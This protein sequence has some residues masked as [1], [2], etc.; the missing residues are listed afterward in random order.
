MIN[1]IRSVR[2]A[3]IGL[4]YVG[5]PLQVAFS[6]KGFRVVGY[7]ID[8][9]RVDELQN[10]DDRTGEVEKKR[11]N[12]LSFTNSID[13]IRA[14]NTYIIT[15]PTPVDS[16]FQPD[17]TPLREASKLISQVC[18]PGDVVIYESTVYPGAT[19]EVCDPIIENESGFILNK[20]F[21]VGY[22]PE[23]INP[24]DRIN[25]LE[26]IVKVTSGSNLESSLYVDWLYS[27]IIDAGT[28]RA[29]SIRVAEASK[30][31]ENCQRDLNIAFVNE[32]SQIFKRLNIDTNEVLDAAATKWNFLNFRP[33]LVGGHCIGVDPYYLKYKAES[34]GYRPDVIM[35]GRHINN[36]MA[37]A[38]VDNLIEL[39]IKRRV[40]FLG[41]KVLILGFTF[42]ENCP[43]IRNTKVIDVVNHLKSLDIDVTI[44]DKLADPNLS[45]RVY[46]VAT[47]GN[48][49]ENGY[50]VV[51]LAVPHQYLLDSGLAYINSLRKDVS[52]FYDL[53]A[54]YPRELSD[55]RL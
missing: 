4:G 6:S 29:S 52:I 55:I 18:G 28:H 37:K 3:V 5:L 33:G 34:T 16:T 22:S 23:R 49:A 51:I 9:N 17:M 39:M 1:D 12:E 41:A 21:Y 7:D 53:K 10:G 26:T 38:V 15:V 31:I 30:V 36:D 25:T 19:E 40:N 45:K 50:D 13:E 2:L 46:G 24:G 35:A 14:C 20:D 54:A 32:L 48:P 43:D 11:L 27:N 44:S 8:G 42:K 47:D